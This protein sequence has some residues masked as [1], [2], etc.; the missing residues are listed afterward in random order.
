L[1]TRS[2]ASDVFLLRSSKWVRSSRS[3]FL[4]GWDFNKN[5]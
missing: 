1:Q 2:R 4:L 3:P 5:Y